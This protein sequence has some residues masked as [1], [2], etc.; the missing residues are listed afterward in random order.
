M[1][2]F[3]TACSLLHIQF[4][5]GCAARQEGAECSSVLGP[6]CLE[7]L[8]QWP[9]TSVEKLFQ[10]EPEKLLAL[11][12]ML[13]LLTTEFSGMGTVELA[14]SMISDAVSEKIQSIDKGHH[15]DDKKL[16]A[17]CLH[18]CDKSEIACQFMKG[19]THPPSHLHRDLFS[20]LSQTA[21]GSMMEAEKEAVEAFNKAT[22]KEGKNKIGDAL[23]ARYMDNLARP[24]SM[25]SKSLCCF[26][27]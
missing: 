8:F 4:E 17:I 1:H 22:D 9:R 12:G 25:V 23:L 14:L 16:K 7:E 20:R 24:R 10:N 15:G 6:S 13:V 27:Q 18:S 26:H 3:S 5:N 2:F 21:Y 19:H 11:K